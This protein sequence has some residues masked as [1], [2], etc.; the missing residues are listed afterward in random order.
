MLLERFGFTPTE[1]KAYSALLRSGPSTGY[2]IAH[3]AGL[4]RANAY[5]ALEGLVRRGGARKTATRPPRFIAIP[6]QSLVS[7]LERRVRRNLDDL[8]DELAQSSVAAGSAAVDPEPLH[9]AATLLARAERCAAGTSRELLAVLGPWVSGLFPVLER[10]RSQRRTLRLL[11]L[12]EP[13]PGGAIVRAVPDR[14]LLG[15]WGGRPLLLISDR[16]SAVC[17]TIHEDGSAT[18]LATTSTGVVPFL[19]HLLRRELASAPAG[20]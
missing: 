6:P 4:A 11:A 15:Y 13:A 1:A 8:K 17:G 3:V 5:Q 10:L 14:E 2:G 19:R 18:G 12:G 7:D 16:T 9:D 20:G